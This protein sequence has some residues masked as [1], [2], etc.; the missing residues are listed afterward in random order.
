MAKTAPLGFGIKMWEGIRYIVAPEYPLGTS[1]LPAAARI[2]HHTGGYLFLLWTSRG[3]IDAQLGAMS[4]HIKVSWCVD[5]FVCVCQ[6]LCF[7]F[8]SSNTQRPIIAHSMSTQCP[9]SVHTQDTHTGHSQHTY[10]YIQQAHYIY[11]YYGHTRRSIDAPQVCP[12]NTHNIYLSD[13]YHDLLL[14]TWQVFARYLKKL[15]A[16][17]PVFKRAPRLSFN[18]FHFYSK[19]ACT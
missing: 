13:R 9:L 7:W 19:K 4:V 17:S 18:Y 11:T 8:P 14:P 5:A 12:H 2:C 16:S 3:I 1:H 15:S 6:M 10:I